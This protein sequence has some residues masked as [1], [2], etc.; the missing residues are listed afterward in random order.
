MSKKN[1]YKG[2]NK[3]L[4]IALLLLLLILAILTAIFLI[5]S[6]REEETPSVI[7][8]DTMQNTV[9]DTQVS[10]EEPTSDMPNPIVLSEELQ[11]LTVSGYSGMYVEDGSNEIVTDVMMVIVENTSMQDL[12][13]AR[14]RLEYSDF[15]ASFEITNLPA[16]EKLVALE[17][18]RHTNV[19]EKPLSVEIDAMVFFP[20]PMD[21]YEDSFRISGSDGVLRV[22]NIS[23]SDIA[24]DILIFY[25][26]SAQDLLYGGI[27]YRIVVRDGLAAGESKQIISGHYSPENSRIISV[28]YG[29]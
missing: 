16:G 12:Q 9:A 17:R 5:T 10:T 26:N 24:G 13:L 1:R 18:N 14:F 4:C 20:E 29:G 19:A 2:N 28:V 21:L 23:G 6:E 11:I 22:E 27:T 3:A 8:E 25:K 7:P 15:T